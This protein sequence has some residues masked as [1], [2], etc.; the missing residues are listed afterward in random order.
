[1]QEAEVR[2]TGKIRPNAKKVLR[3]YELVLIKGK[4]ID[5]FYLLLFYSAHDDGGAGPRPRQVRTQC[6]SCY[7]T[8]RIT[9]VTV[10]RE[11]LR[12]SR[13]LLGRKSPSQSSYP[14]YVPEFSL[15][16]SII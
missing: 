13:V 3:I 12:F 5:Q 10:S 4:N 9:P 8:H 1:L 2:T 7:V 15:V 6:V 14:L 11:S 16:T